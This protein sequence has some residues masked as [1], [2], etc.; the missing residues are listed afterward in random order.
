VADIASAQ[1]QSLTMLRKDRD[2]EKEELRRHCV[3][4]ES[5]SDDDSMIGK[6]Q[7]VLMSTKASYRAFARKHEI[8]RSNLRRKE[9]MIKALESRLDEREETVYRIHEES[10]QRL[11]IL[12]RALQIVML[13]GI[14]DEDES[15]CGPG[16][17]VKTTTGKALSLFD[18]ARALSQRVM[19]LAHLSEQREAEM[20]SGAAMSKKLQDKIEQL[21]I[22]K[23][24]SRFAPNPFNRRWHSFIMKMMMMIDGVSP[25]HHTNSSH[26]L[27]TFYRLLPLS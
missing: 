26:I 21:Q 16:L 13:Q 18:R 14:G 4:L 8:A 7:R 5:R 22:E 3:E 6:L 20:K 23:Q 24:V 1:I 12:R 25:S 11:T 19:E 9:A 2:E 27:F 10:R 17:E 15:I